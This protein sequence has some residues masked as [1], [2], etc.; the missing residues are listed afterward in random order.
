MR[1]LIVAATASSNFCHLFKSF[2]YI[3]ILQL[4][5]LFN[6]LYNPI[7]HIKFN[8]RLYKTANA[9]SE[10]ETFFFI[11]LRATSAWE[12]STSALCVTWKAH[13]WR[14]FGSVCEGAPKWDVPYKNL[15]KK[16]TCFH[17]GSTIYKSNPII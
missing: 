9:N 2:N 12:F 5:Y 16:P 15:L 11:L 6:C 1:L 10:S 3:F 4:S 8:F 7:S 14:R 13:V 17:F